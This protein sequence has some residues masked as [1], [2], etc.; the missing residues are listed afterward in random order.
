MRILLGQPP[1][2][3]KTLEQLNGGFRQYVTTQDY[4]EAFFRI[5]DLHPIITASE[6]GGLPETTLPRR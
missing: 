2:G 5:V 1:S 3:D 6:P 4:G